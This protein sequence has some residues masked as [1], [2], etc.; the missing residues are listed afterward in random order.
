MITVFGSINIDL[1]TRVARTPGPGETVRGSDYRLIPG[2]KGANQA[3]AARRAGASVRLLGAIGYDAFADIALIELKPAGVDVSGVARPSATTGLAI[4]TVDDKGENTIVVSPGANAHATAASI[5]LGIFGP[6]D[7][8]LLQ[9]EVPFAESLA[10]AKIARAAG[11]RVILSVAPYTALPAEDVAAFDVIIVNEH[12]AADLAKHLGI[13]AR[14]ADATVTALARRLG[15]T[16]IATLGP[17]GAI[18][19]TGTEVIRVPA[20]KVT[21]VDTTGAG[22]TFCGVLA[23]YLDEGAD[24]NTAMRMAAIA[25]SLAVTKEGAQPSFPMRAAIDAASRN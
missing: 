9:M 16:V 7:T 20:L 13:A 19:A 11:T 14:G 22:D 25:G 3:L 2:G 23:A 8:L 21:P 1:V 10:A 18:A 17:E 12:E 6:R 15:H 24:L 5:P 4:I